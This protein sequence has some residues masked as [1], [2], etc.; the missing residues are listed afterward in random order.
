M[1]PSTYDAATRH[2]I[3]G[4]LDHSVIVAAYRT[5]PESNESMESNQ[6]IIG[7]LAPTRLDAPYFRFRGPENE[8]M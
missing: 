8:E 7:H 5:S 1:L 3:E 6:T 2:K 4:T